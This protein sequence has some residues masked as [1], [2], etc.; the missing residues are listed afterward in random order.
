MLCDSSENLSPILFD[1]AQSRS[2]L[3]NI[4]LELGNTSFT[5]V[6]HEY[7]TKNY[8]CQHPVLIGGT[9]IEIGDMYRAKSLID[10]ASQSYLFS[11]G[12]Q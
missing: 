12:N 8:L 7:E 9:A 3:C 6:I 4:D 1:L 2:S 11:Y 10:M 5:Q